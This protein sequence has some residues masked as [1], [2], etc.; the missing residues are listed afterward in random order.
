MNDLG[1]NIRKVLKYGI[2][3]YTVCCIP[4]VNAHKI[5]LEKHIY[6][7]DGFDVYLVN[8]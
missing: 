7:E 2:V 8:E 1:Y 6:Y 4:S 3:N 5:A